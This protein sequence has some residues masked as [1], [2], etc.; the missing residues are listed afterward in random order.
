V[1]RRSLIATF[2]LVTSLIAW[3]IPA[4]AADTHVPKELTRGFS[5]NDP[6]AARPAVTRFAVS[7]NDGNDVKGDLDLRSTKI[8]RGKTKD[9]IL[10]TAFGP[11]SNADIDPDNG[12][13]AVLIDT[14]N[15]KDFDYA[16]YV[17]F[18]AGKLRGVLVKLPS[19]NLVDRTAPASRT[20]PRA[21]RT[22]I[23]R[24]KI[25]SPGTYRFAVFGFNQASPCSKRK[26]CVDTVPNKFPLIPL[27]HKSPSI[28]VTDMELHSTDVSDDLTSP[29]TFSVEDDK[30][31]TGVK[32][33]TVQSKEVGADAGWT[34]VTTGTG[35]NPIV[36]VPGVEGSTYDVRIVVLDKQKNKLVSPIER[37]SF[38]FDDRNASITYVGTTAQETRG[39]SFL[40]T[41][42]TV[43]QTTTAT[44]A[45]MGSEVCVIG[46]PVGATLTASV[47]VLLDDVAQPVLSEDET[48]P[49]R[50]T[51]GCLTTTAGPHTLKLTGTS[52]TP[53]VLDGIYATP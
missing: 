39:S 34:N 22:D 36:D 37:T 41:V 12:N 30:F 23:Q 38:P 11:V 35:K 2:A 6:V 18:A 4:S 10:F 17:F 49:E 46:G 16:Q 51:F 33:W 3:A 24:G 20:S 9:S 44:L 45:F 50:T 5:D 13:W 21:F 42:T 15:D 1:S 48:T 31:G 47:D 53:F 43:S 28:E 25:N 27:D 52:A 32:R 7:R 29:L 40:Q 8:S 19:G 14:N 26:P